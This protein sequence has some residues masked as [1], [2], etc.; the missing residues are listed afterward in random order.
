M[1]IS[2]ISVAV[3]N[4]KRYQVA[5]I[6]YKNQ[7]G[8][9][10]SWKL[11]S[12]ANPAAFAALKDAKE[13]ELYEVTTGKDDKDYTVWTGATKISG[14]AQA[15]GQGNAA[16]AKAAWVPDSDRQRLIVKQSSLGHAIELIKYLEVPVGSNQEVF[17][18]ADQIVAYVYD[19]PA[20][21][22]ATAE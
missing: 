21:E 9:T 6:S 12:F 10:K 4:V 11:I 18:L 15:A 13:G 1:Q 2:I 5:E 7:R 20:V 16:P 3:S 22:T 8:E 17:D 19:V 14:D